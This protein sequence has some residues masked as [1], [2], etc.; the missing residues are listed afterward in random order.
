MIQRRV[1]YATITKTHVEFRGFDQTLFPGFDPIDDYMFFPM[2]LNIDDD[3]ISPEIIRLD[4][5]GQEVIISNE[6][7]GE[8]YG[9]RWS[10]TKWDAR[11][12]RKFAWKLIES[13]RDRLDD[14]CDVVYQKT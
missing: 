11:T 14:E 12:G 13:I 5:D 9:V 4:D 7:C 2:K 6:Y 8:F 3:W 10:I 1:I